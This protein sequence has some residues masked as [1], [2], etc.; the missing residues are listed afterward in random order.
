MPARRRSASAG[1]SSHRRARSRCRSARSPAAN[2]AS[3]STRSHRACRRVCARRRIISRTF[4]AHGKRLSIESRV[5][6]GT[7]ETIVRSSPRIALSTTTCRRSLPI[8][9]SAS[10]CAVLRGASAVAD[11][12]SRRASRRA[13]AVDRRDGKRFSEAEPRELAVHRASAFGIRFV[14]D[15]QHRMVRAPQDAGN[16]DVDRVE[17]IDGIDDEDDHVGVAAAFSA[18]SRVRTRSRRSD[19]RRTRCRRV[20]ALNVRPR[21]SASA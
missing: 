16:V 8:S 9:A 15:E 20:D 17:A 2:A 10:S 1:P 11:R 3:C 14:R 19:R 6:P 7:S 4:Y 12:R 5:V 13:F 18:C 21:Q